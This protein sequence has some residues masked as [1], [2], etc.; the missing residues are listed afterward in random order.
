M[1]Q[2]A[3]RSVNHIF[4]LKVFLFSYVLTAVLLMLLAML[5][6]KLR[7]SEMVVNI[8][9]I[10]IYIA[11]CFLSGFITGKKME[12][13]KFIWGLLMGT[14]YFLILALLSAILM[15]G[16]LDLSGNFFS[17]MFLCA[18]SGMLGGMLS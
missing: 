1:E 18:G 10:L 16:A 3:K 4:F 2:T 5:L 9:I 7:L 12:N 15:R 13:K 11:A 17:T 8:G 14:G 6:Y